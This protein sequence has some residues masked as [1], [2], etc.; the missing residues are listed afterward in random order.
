M[1]A[2]RT[3]DDR[4]VGLPDWDFEP[5]YLTDLDGYEGLRAHYVDVGPRDADRTFLLLHGEPS[6]SFLYR[7]M[8][9]VFEQAGARVVAPDFFGFGRSDKPVEREAY[10][11]DFHREYLLR[12]V[13]RLD[14]TNITLVVQ[15]WGGVLGL[16]LPVDPGF[17]GR[18]DRLLVMNTAIA[19]GDPPT[20]AFEAWRDYC[21]ANPDLWPGDVVRLTEP[22]LSDAEA[23]AYN[24][25]FPDITYK[26]GA[27]V[28]PDLVMTSPDMPGVQT[29]LQ[30]L[31][32]W[33]G[34]AGPVFMAVGV[35]DPILGVEAMQVLR[36][37]IGNC[38][39]PLLVDA[40]HFVQEQGEEVARAAL[41]AFG[42]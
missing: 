5:H 41:T 22:R 13:E 4:F 10:T 38:P 6:W 17:A 36:E 29:S 24:A 12:L 34:W 1:T 19:A 2:L 33:S 23:A 40:G 15:D 14:L 39:E 37:R 27:H 7:K 21:R 8:I 30:A 11:F 32:F 26:V 3:P 35:N 9:P 31:D 20:P 28:F 25:P 18:L 42:D 16:T